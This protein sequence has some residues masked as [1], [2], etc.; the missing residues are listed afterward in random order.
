MKGSEI[1]AS[2]ASIAG[3]AMSTPSPARAPSSLL[4]WIAQP[5]QARI[6][7][8]TPTIATSSHGF[9]RTRPTG[10]S[11]PLADRGWSGAPTGGKVPIRGEGT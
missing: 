1:S 4:T 11:S 9:E 6:R 8:A 3:Q 7:I 2:A 5:I 10:P